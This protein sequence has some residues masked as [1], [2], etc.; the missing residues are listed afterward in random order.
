MKRFLLIIIEWYYPK[1]GINDVED[2]VE[3]EQEALDWYNSKAERFSKIDS[4]SVSV[5]VFDCE[6]REIIAKWSSEH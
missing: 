2:S 1:G 3:T 5:Q 4:P 6:E